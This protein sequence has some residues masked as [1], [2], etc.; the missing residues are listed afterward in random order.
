MTLPTNS[1]IRGYELRELIGRGGFGDVYRALQPTVGREVAIKVISPQYANDPEFI[2]CFDAEAHLV[3]RLEH[4]HVVPLYDYWREPDGAYLV[5]RYLKAGSLRDGLGHGPWP[6]EKALKLAVQIGGALMA[7]H[8]QRVVHRDVKPE[9]ILLDGDGNAY[10]TDFGIAKDVDRFTRQ[11]RTG[12][13]TGSL[14]YVSPEQV[15]SQPVTAASDQYSLGIVLYEALSG[16]HPFPNETPSGMLLKHLN[17]PL[18]ALSSRVKGLPAGLEDV[19]RRATAK[20]PAKRYPDVLALA[21]DFRAALENGPRT[22][23][24]VETGEV[25]ITTPNPYKGLSAFQEADA[26]DFFGREALVARLLDR[27]NEESVLAQFLAVVGPS[28]SGKSSVVKAGLLPE[29]RRGGA[30]GSQGWYMVEMVP[31]A[32]PLEELEVCLLRIAANKS[33]ALMEQLRRDDRGLV[34][35]ARLALPTENSTLLLVIDQFEE[36]FTLVENKA[37]AAHF[38]NSLYAAV[39]TPRSPVRV[40]ITLRADF[41]DRPLMYPNFAEL[42]RQ[43]T[44]V[45]LP[46]TAEELSR[47]ITAPAERVGARY[48]AGLVSQIVVDVNDQ[49]GALPLLEYALTELFERRSGRQLTRAAYAAIGGVLGAVSRRAEEVYARMNAEAQERACQMFLRLV[50]LGEGVEDTRRRVLRSELES[51][52]TLAG[53]TP[54]N[55]S[56]AAVI[57][58]FGAARLLAFDR[59][60]LTRG[61]T[62]EVAHEALLREWKRLREWLDSS[63]TEVRLQRLLAA[64]AAEWESFGRDAS[65]LLQGARLAQFEIWSTS[66]QVALTQSEQDYLQVSLAEQARLAAAENLRQRQE[67]ETSQRLAEERARAEEQTAAAKRLRSRNRWVV[68]LAILAAFLAVLAGAFG[69]SAEISRKLSYSRELTAAALNSIETDS[70]RAGLLALQALETAR[71]REGISA[72]HQI[73]P[74]L[75]LL[76]SLPFADQSIHQVISPDGNF[77]AFAS[78]DG[79]VQIQDARTGKAVSVL[80]GHVDWVTAI[81]FS[82][83]GKSVASAGKDGSVR[84]WEIASGKEIKKF[85]TN[86]AD[87]NVLAFSLDGAWIAVGGNDAT[88]QIWE[89]S[90]GNMLIDLYGHVLTTLTGSGVTG[91]T[92]IH[93][94]PVSAGAALVST[95]VDGRICVWDLTDPTQ[96]VESIKIETNEITSA[97]VS[98]DGSLIAAGEYNGSV[99]VWSLD[100]SEPGRLVLT[101]KDDQPVAAVA[102]SPDGK[103]IA[104]GDKLRTTLWNAGSGSMQVTLYAPGYG[105][106]FNPDGTSL[107]LA[108]DSSFQTYDIGPDREKLAWICSTWAASAVFSR[109]GK[110]LYVGCGDGSI[111]IV[112][113]FTGEILNTIKHHSDNIVNMAISPDGARLTTASWDGNA[114]VID[115]KSG[116]VLHTISAVDNYVSGVA[117]S[118]DGKLLALSGIE[119]MVKVYDTTAYKEVQSFAIA[120]PQV[121]AFSPDGKYV[122]SG[123]WKGSPNIYIWEVAS[124]NLSMTLDMPGGVH[125]VAFSP[126]GKRLAASA[127]TTDTTVW[128]I[129]SGKG[130]VAYRFAGHKLG[131]YLAYSRDGKQLATTGYDGKTTVW[132]AENGEELFTLTGARSP[133]LYVAFSPQGDRLVT[134]NND[135]LALLYPL[136]LDDLI[137]LAKS[138]LTRGLSLDEC[139]QFLHASA[140]PK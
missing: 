10:L 90:S 39:T 11:S 49:P 41:Y 131:Y 139:R 96:P 53:N 104:V 100:S 132:N 73:I 38:L 64:A 4:P 33:V 32:H 103:R 97:S 70:Q 34:R 115:S 55:A 98:P 1:S 25:L 137:A 9:N 121:V 47:A 91:I 116:L 75:R 45:V 117:Y 21:D 86:N 84:L 120:E 74:T 71:T 107:D 133:I 20:D 52:R 56:M 72:L 83:D 89:V 14:A 111:Q 66:T 61:P 135:G 123:A 119:G 48:E 28:G 65:F 105:F 108:S 112:D 44:E 26:P 126:D 92:S 30:P 124:G 77:L 6:P 82:P 35:A 3:A 51:L 102:F 40:L 129:A 85:L 114:N 2:R 18:P 23:T 78:I 122:A 62:V 13:I 130:K 68:S 50:T 36:V 87:V 17:E 140:C 63:R 67:K 24:V 128:D 5:M 12:V 80:Q 106:V 118:P 22:T 19:L 110:W 60:P 109:D 31:G 57:D 138:R 125:C 94:L 16:A 136:G 46:L 54:V 7:A 8:R 59:D 43:R 127:L 101:I 58:A 81:A 79:A 76:R 27:M 93:F 42:V 99:E 134:T 29:L 15:Q 37:E 69:I 95:G 88:V 113:S